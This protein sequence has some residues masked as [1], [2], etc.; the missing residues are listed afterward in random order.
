MK[1]ITVVMSVSGA[2]KS[3]IEQALSKHVNVPYLDAEDFHPKANLMKMNNGVALT[4]DDRWNGWP[5]LSNMSLTL[6]EQS[7]C[8]PA[9]P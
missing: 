4:D 7:L 3:T 8:W 6:I 2:G 5:P 1:G 9:Q